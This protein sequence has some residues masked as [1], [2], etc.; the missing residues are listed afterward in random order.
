MP[1]MEGIYMGWGGGGR[2]GGGG[3]S[4]LWGCTS[5]GDYVVACQVRITIHYSGSLLLHLCDIFQVLINAFVDSAQ[6][7]W[8]SFCFRFWTYTYQHDPP[9]SQCDFMYA[10]QA[11]L[12][13]Y[14]LS[15]TGSQHIVIQP[16]QTAQNSGARLI[17]RSTRRQTYAPSGTLLASSELHNN[18]KHAVSVSG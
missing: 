3:A 9:V 1:E 2:G 13:L 6:A 7:F 5:C 17:F 11:W 8:S 16:L 15:L 10:F 12:E 18:T 4:F 14:F